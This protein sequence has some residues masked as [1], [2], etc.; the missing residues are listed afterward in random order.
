MSA[1]SMIIQPESSGRL[2]TLTFSTLFCTMKKIHAD[3]GKAKYGYNTIRF[4][5]AT[6]PSS[7]EIQKKKIPGEKFFYISKISTDSL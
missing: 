6:E 1:T 4:P 2:H 7:E 3:T 5:R